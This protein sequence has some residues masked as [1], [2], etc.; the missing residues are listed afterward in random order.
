MQV[1]KLSLYYSFSWWHVQSCL[2][3][4][5]FSL[6]R[7]L[8]LSHSLCYRILFAIV[9]SLL[10]HSFVDLQKIITYIYANK[11]VFINKKLF[12]RVILIKLINWKHKWLYS[13]LSRI[14]DRIWSSLVH[15]SYSNRVVDCCWLDRY[16]SC[17]LLN[18]STHCSFWFSMSLSLVIHEYLNSRAIYNEVL[19]LSF[20]WLVLYLQ[21]I[22]LI[23][24]FSFLLF[25]DSSS[26]HYKSSSHILSILC[27]HHVDLI[28]VDFYRQHSVL[29]LI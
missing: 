24:N 8:L 13:T 4:L 9:F 11:I 12:A 6:S 23:S 7:I 14:E 19:F 21:F 3:I 20:S 2:I 26:W 25:F 18:I 15:T 28:A 17:K 10:S 16:F 29:I 5:S 1:D 27:F 22:I